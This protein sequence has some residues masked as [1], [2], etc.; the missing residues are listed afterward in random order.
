MDKMELIAAAT[1]CQIA[2]RE[3]RDKARAMRKAADDLDRIAGDLDGRG[4]AM[5]AAAVRMAQAGAK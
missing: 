2:A 5:G 3:L 1:D 4:S